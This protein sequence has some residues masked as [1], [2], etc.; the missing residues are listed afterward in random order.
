MLVLIAGSFPEHWAAG[1][2]SL[3]VGIAALSRCR[4]IGCAEMAAVLRIC[5]NTLGLRLKVDRHLHCYLLALLT[6]RAVI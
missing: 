3:C 5:P 2:L 4:V 1:Q 6:Q